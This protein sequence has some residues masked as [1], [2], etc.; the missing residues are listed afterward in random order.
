M[1]KET[2]GTDVFRHFEE[3]DASRMDNPTFVL[4]SI[5]F[6]ACSCVG[7][8]SSLLPR[9]SLNVFRRYSRFERFV[10]QGVVWFIVSG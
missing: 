2:P 7:Y 3:L 8:V 5:G 10:D 1:A 6:G 4:S 9:A